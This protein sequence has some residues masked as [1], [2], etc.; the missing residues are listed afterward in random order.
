MALAGSSD[1]KADCAGG[2]S[3]PSSNHLTAEDIPRAGCLITGPSFLRAAEPPA[4][5]MLDLFLRVLVSTRLHPSPHISS[6]PT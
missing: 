2:N 4:V 3:R 5:A 6:L 1:S